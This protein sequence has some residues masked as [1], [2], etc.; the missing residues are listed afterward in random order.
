MYKIMK[1]TSHLNVTVKVSE[2]LKEKLANK[3]AA[4][5]AKAKPKAKKAEKAETKPAKAE[6]AKVDVDSHSGLDPESQEQSSAPE[7]LNQVQG[8]DAVEEVKQEAQEAQEV[9]EDVECAEAHK[10]DVNVNQEESK[11]ED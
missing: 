1:R 7:T 4:E 2:E 8:D 10:D 9:Q 11:Q 3:K 6:E 5:K